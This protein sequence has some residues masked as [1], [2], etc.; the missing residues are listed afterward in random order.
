MKRLFFLAF[1]FS[2]V[3]A[4]A[5]SQFTF[6]V[7]PE[8][9]VTKKLTD[10][11]R[12]S[13]QVESMQQTVFALAGETTDHYKYIRTDL[14]GIVSYSLNPRWGVAAGSLARFTEGEFVYRSLQQ[15][16]Y[17][18]TGVSLRFGQRLRADQTFEPDEDA[19][20][21]LR[22]R[23]SAEIPL[24]G[25]RVDPNEFYLLASV[26][27]MAILKSAEWDWEQRFSPALG[28]YFSTNHN[29]EIGLDY[30][31]NEFINDNDDGVHALWTMINYK[32]NF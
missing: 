18:H 20:F 6:G 23:F 9:T 2:A 17:N 5:Q 1:V 31:V 10:K 8:V 12:V 25:L 7:L 22:Y 19:E 26:E 16:S 30:R 3:L 24:Q 11:W 29:L 27:Q 32:V 4:K 28:Y 13:G 14:T 15:V 21:R